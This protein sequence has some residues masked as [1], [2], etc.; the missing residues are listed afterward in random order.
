M[1]KGRAILLDTCVIQYSLSKEAQLRE[2]TGAFIAE[3]LKNKNRLFVSDFTYYELLKGANKDNKAKAEEKLNHFEEIPQTKDRLER[4]TLLYSAYLGEESVK[5]VLS[6][7]SEIDAFIGSL[8]FN[9]SR[10]LLLTADFNDFPRPFF[11][12]VEVK[13]I[14]YE[15]GRGNKCTHYYYFL[16]ANLELFR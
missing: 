10:P 2:A 8:I 5:P 13:P 3:L 15:K 12:E 4:A 7:I 14:E 16:E 6:S 1:I 9:N 11:K